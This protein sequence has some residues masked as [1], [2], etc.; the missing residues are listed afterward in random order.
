MLPRQQNIVF[1]NGLQN[2]P[3]RFELKYKI[4]RLIQLLI[5]NSRSDE[6]E[7]AVNNK[8]YRNQPFDEFGL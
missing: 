4:L 8:N 7:K 1:Y 3:D 6:I 5:S 2:Q